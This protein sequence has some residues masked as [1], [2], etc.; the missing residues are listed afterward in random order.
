MSS[1]L[2]TLTANWDSLHNAA[3]GR[4]TKPLVPETTA[5]IVEERFDAFRAWRDSWGNTPLTDFADG[6]AYDLFSGELRDQEAQYN[7][8]RVIVSAVLS[9][10]VLPPSVTVGSSIERAAEDAA[11]AVKNAASNAATG[12]WVVAGAGVVGAAGFIIHKL[13]GKGHR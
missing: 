10:A 13:F 11:Q 1:R 3:F 4:T 6:A 12:L 5:T 2:D 8:T 7:A 9:E